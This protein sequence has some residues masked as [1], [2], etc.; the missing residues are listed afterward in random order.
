VVIRVLDS[1]AALGPRIAPEFEFGRLRLTP[2]LPDEAVAWVV[3]R[4]ISG[5][6]A[7]VVTSH[8][9]HVR[10]AE[11]DPAFLDVL[12]RCEL[13]VADGWPLVAMSRVLRPRLPSRV[14]GI[15]LTDAVLQAGAAL[16]VAI[17]GGPPGAAE[18]LAERE[19][20][21]NNVVLVEPL[22]AG[23]WEQPDEYGAM[24]ERL[25]AAAP[26]LVLLGVGAPRQEILADALRPYIRGPVLCCGATIPVLAGT[27][28]R[29]PSLM[30]RV[31]M[32]WVFRLFQSPRRLGPRYLRGAG[33]FSRIAC[34]ELGYRV[35]QA[36]RFRVQ[37]SR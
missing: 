6:A 3:D 25:A 5:R 11:T 27:V 34:R 4:A 31:G 29:A 10:L 37:A 18:A 9:H 12:N 7:V 15:D 33:V 24:L 26:N 17:L 19:S 35:R 28:R 2:A 20:E 1:P 16:D 14:I 8:L 30:R 23:I 13:N 22:E 21:R 32:E 36:I